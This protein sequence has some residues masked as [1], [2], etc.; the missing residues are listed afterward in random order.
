MKFLVYVAV[1]LSTATC[2]A[3]GLDFMTRPEPGSKLTAAQTEPA[4][5]KGARQAD[6]QTPQTPNA[7]QQASATGTVR[8]IPIV[9]KANT[10]DPNNELTPI[11]PAAPGKD[12]PVKDAGAPKEAP[13]KQAVAAAAAAP[14]PVATARTET[15]GTAPSGDAPPTAKPVAVAAPATLQPASST[16]SS[17]P[18]STL[19]SSLQ[20]SAPNSCNV[21]A[22]AAAYRSFRE[23]DC[24]YQ[25]FEGPRKICEGAP[26]S[27]SPVS[28][29][30]QAAINPHPQLA[31]QARPDS[32]PG[33]RRPI[34]AA[35]DNR[36][37]YVEDLQDATRAVRRLP[38]P[39]AR[40]EYD[41]DEAAPPPDMSRYG[42]R[43]NW[44]I[45]QE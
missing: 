24:T 32:R 36:D 35:R 14:A 37:M 38:R 39:N 15:N 12:L 41:D 7:Q 13:A 27:S 33:E 45:E 1:L 5:L 44:I 2:L 21:A 18:S 26:Q 29:P 34:Q 4:A 42:L 30:Q 11:Y 16:S 17:Q 25:P 31:P 8:Q 28:A 10:G 22:C 19:R 3:L 43:Q 9:G 20:A 23:S 40:Y 6:A